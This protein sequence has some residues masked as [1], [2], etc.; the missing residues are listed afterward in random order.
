MDKNAQRIDPEHLS[1][2]YTARVIPLNRNA[3][4]YNRLKN[5]NP[6]ILKDTLKDHPT[7]CLSPKYLSPKSQQTCLQL[8]QSQ[9][10][11]AKDI[12]EQLH[13]VRL[14]SIDDSPCV[15]LDPKDKLQTFK[16]DNEIC[17]ALQ[18]M[19]FL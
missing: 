18:R 12:Q 6:K 17:L 7:M 5:D 13:L 14:I 4:F 8:F 1:D 16:S 19:K 10:Y 15:Y 11:N 3:P 9:T 2:L